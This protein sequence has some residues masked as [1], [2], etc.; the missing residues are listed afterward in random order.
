MSTGI[1]TVF[2]FLLLANQKIV[3]AE[4]ALKTEAGAPLKILVNRDTK[5]HT[6]PNSEAKGRPVRQ[7][8]FYFVLPADE[9]DN[10]TK[11]GFYRVSAKPNKAEAAGWIPETECVEWPHMMCI[12]FFPNPEREPGYF[13]NSPDDAKSYLESG[14]A[15]QRVSEEIRGGGLEIRALLPV[16]AYEQ[17]QSGDELISLYK[18]CYVHD[19]ADV[20][21]GAQDRD[22]EKK[23]RKGLKLEVV[24]VLDT[25][26][27][28]DPFIEGALKV[29]ED[30]S[31]KLKGMTQLEDR[32]RLGLVYYK[33]NDDSS[34][35]VTKIA[36]SLEEGEDLNK[37]KSQLTNQ[38][39]DKAS[40]GGDIPEQVFDGVL[41]AVEKMKWSDYAG[42]HIILIGD[43]PNHGP[44]KTTTSLQRV[45][46]AAQ[47][48]SDG[49]NQSVLKNIVIH[50]M[51]LG[52]PNSEGSDI[53]KKQ[54]AELA[55]GKDFPGQSY[56]AKSGV[57]DQE[58]KPFIA[59]LL[60]LL[61][62][63][64]DD[65]SNSLSTDE[66]KRSEFIESD[67]PTS[68][69]LRTVLKNIIGE[70]RGGENFNF[71]YA[72]S[73]DSKG[74]K[75]FDEFVLLKKGDLK[76]YVRLTKFSVDSIKEAGEPGSRDV[77]KILED[78]QRL[79]TNTGYGSKVTGDTNLKDL[80]SELISALPIRSD[81]L[82]KTIDQLAALPQKEFDDW[83]EKITA[84][85]EA[86]DS[87]VNNA[88]WINLGDEAGTENKD[89]ND[90]SFAFIRRTELP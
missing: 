42:R 25:T 53:G 65:T 38:L 7:F 61:S 5:L 49:T 67:D 45:V 86:M 35:Y 29:I 54:F 4:D 39:K 19:Q 36:C 73:I 48:T 84:S 79:A 56:V 26:K 8:S 81:L 58:T 34:D 82:N 62:R 3:H 2:L 83:V 69:P 75:S 57:R 52:N 30:I 46:A 18:T 1:C 47:P 21:A 87:H 72:A 44:E 85:C 37:F 43:A 77:E 71:G 22:L 32:V 20:E 70:K 23:I 66:R 16:L 6:E 88:T 10:K 55:Q 90:S 59:K 78:M 64:L 9:K 80:L 68:Q 24:F 27:S 31:V 13:F 14:D 63:A 28:M 15:S 51:F 41:T 76:R 40:G 11:N 74:N 33:D 17:V 50:T 89:E 60:N 12:G